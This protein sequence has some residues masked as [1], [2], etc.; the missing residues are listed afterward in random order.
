MSQD[1][2]AGIKCHIILNV[3]GEVRATGLPWNALNLFRNGTDLH[4]L[5]YFIV[6]LK[7]V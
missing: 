5:N 3:R 4:D 7:A 2:I 6:N 1:Y